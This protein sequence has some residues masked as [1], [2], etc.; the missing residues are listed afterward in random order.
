MADAWSEV[1]EATG[2]EQL[3]SLLQ[4]LLT[5]DPQQRADASV[6]MQ[7][8]FL[9][10]PATLPRAAL[11]LDPC[12]APL[13]AASVGPP[14]LEKLL[15]VPGMPCAYY[16]PAEPFGMAG[17]GALHWYASASCSSCSLTATI[18]VLSTILLH[19]SVLHALF[20]HV[21]TLFLHFLQGCGLPVQLL[22]TQLCVLPISRCDGHVWL[23]PTSSLLSSG[24]ACH[25][26][27]CCHTLQALATH[28]LLQACGATEN[29][30]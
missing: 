28:L 5:Y 11:A 4:R 3:V 26:Q 22:K 15:Q 12:K 19:I 1:L 20:L 30:T 6:I 8:P 18:H 14:A 16:D 10:Q 2:S 17:S 13:A 9:Q 7:H 23:A 21:H 29:V 25:A 27:A 24:E